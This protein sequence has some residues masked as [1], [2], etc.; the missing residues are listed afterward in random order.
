MGLAK[1]FATGLEKL[2]P[3]IQVDAWGAFVPGRADIVEGL[4][5]GVIKDVTERELPNLEITT[6]PLDI[7]RDNIDKWFRAGE[8]RDYIFFTDHL[9]KTAAA[10]VT[11]RIAK[12]GTKDM[13]LSWRLFEGNP[14]KGVFKVALEGVKIYIGAAVAGAGL[15]TSIFGFGAIAIPIGLEMISSG[16]DN[17]RGKKT[18]R[19]LTAEQQLDARI[20]VQ[21][22][23]YC[24]MSQ[25]EKFGVSSDELRILQAS[26]IEGIGRL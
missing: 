5:E 17:I 2:N 24:L 16:I 26:R 6:G 15:L 7:A 3:E 20:L 10:M 11:L 14:A 23:D 22:I 13:E 18:E 1:R 4:R 9:G 21:T 25:L 19:N 12:R 8:P